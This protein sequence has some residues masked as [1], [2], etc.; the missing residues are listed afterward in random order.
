MCGHV[1]SIIARLV[2]KV[3]DVPLRV[4]PAFMLRKRAS[5][6]QFVRNANRF[7]IQPDVPRV[8]T[9]DANPQF[10]RL[11]RC[12]IAISNV[13]QVRAWIAGYV[14]ALENLDLPQTRVFRCVKLFELHRFGNRELLLPAARADLQFDPG[15][16]FGKCASM[17]LVKG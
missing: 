12:S 7:L 5:R 15:W 16:I 3:Q 10:S 11:I 8:A 9:N 1:D 6:A 2:R 14:I 13:D 4:G 17:R